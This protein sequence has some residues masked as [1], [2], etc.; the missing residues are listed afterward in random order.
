MIYVCS[1]SNWFAQSVH[2]CVCV[3]V[4]LFT[5]EVLLK[6]LFAPTSQ[7]L[8]S[9]IFRDLGKSNAKIWKLLPIKGAKSPLQKKFLRI[10]FHLFTLFKRLFAPISWS[11]MSKL[12]RFSESL[13]KSKWNKWPQIWKLLLIQGVKLLCKQKL[14]FLQILPY[15]QDLLVSVLLSA[16]VEICYVSRMQDFC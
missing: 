1:G 5:F 6:G 16:S 3:S 12:F 2:I 15:Y 4:C 13:Q 10:F 7:S 8:M 11:P 14:V 9:K